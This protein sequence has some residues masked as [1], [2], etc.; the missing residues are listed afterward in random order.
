MR[1]RSAQD[2]CVPA[3]GGVPRP[4]PSPTARPRGTRTCFPHAL[5]GGRACCSPFGDATEG[6]AVLSLEPASGR[7]CFRCRRFFGSDLRHVVRVARSSPPRRPAQR[8]SRD[9]RSRAPRG[10]EPR[11]VGAGKRL[12][13][14]RNREIGLAG[15]LDTGTAVFA[16]GNPGG[17][18][19]CGSTATARSNPQARSRTSIG[20]SNISPDGT[21]AVVRHGGHLWIHD[22]QRGTRSPLTSGN[23]STC[24]RCGAATANGSSSRRIEGR[25]G[26]LLATRRRIA[27]R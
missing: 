17:P 20:R 19:S 8:Q 24:F 11:C 2:C 15:R 7:W 3:A 1:H 4:S 27:A 21:K 6:N 25:L 12:L 22:L 5:P 13:Q 9:V 23:Q 18:H 16:S 10:Y 14:H 26:H